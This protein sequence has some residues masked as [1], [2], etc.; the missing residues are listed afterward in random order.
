MR[1]E[2]IAERKREKYSRG[3]RCRGDNVLRQQVRQVFDLNVS[4]VCVV[5]AELVCECVVATG[6]NVY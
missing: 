4:R 6:A 3:T 1:D 2:C 5:P